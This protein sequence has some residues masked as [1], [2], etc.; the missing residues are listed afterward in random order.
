MN[1]GQKIWTA[2]C[3]IAFI[4]TL[5]WFPWESQYNRGHCF[6]LAIQSQA[7]EKPIRPVWS[8]VI[9]EWGAL[10]IV[11]GGLFGLLKSRRP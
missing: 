2:V 11:Y 7:S 8:E 10:A 3:L 6:F 5:F 1:T 4:T 9:T